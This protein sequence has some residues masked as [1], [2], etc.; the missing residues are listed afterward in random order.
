M[1]QTKQKGCLIKIVFH[2][3]RETDFRTIWEQ[4]AKSGVLSYWWSSFLTPCFGLSWE[5][6]K[7][8]FHLGDNKTLTQLNFGIETMTPNAMAFGNFDT[9]TLTL[10]AFDIE[11]ALCQPGISARQPISFGHIADLAVRSIRSPFYLQ[12]WDRSLFPAK[13]TVEEVQI[14]PTF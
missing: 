5:E 8:R 12:F 13:H 4:L 14:F 6:I 3:E 1:P 11:F 9:N 2:V 10:L 7:Y